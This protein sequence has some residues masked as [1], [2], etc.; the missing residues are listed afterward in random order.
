MINSIRYSPHIDG[1]YTDLRDYIVSVAVKTE[2]PYSRDSGAGLVVR[3]INTTND[4][5]LRGI[6]FLKEPGRCCSIFYFHRGKLTRQASY[7][8]PPLEDHN[9][10][11]F[12]TIRIKASGNRVTFII[13]GKVVAEKDDECLE[14]SACV[15]LM[16]IGPG[17]FCFDDLELWLYVISLAPSYFLQVC[18]DSSYTG[19]NVMRICDQLRNGQLVSVDELIYTVMQLG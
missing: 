8:L 6:L 4:E 12:E 16:A 13:N 17:T 14:G 7:Q 2:R 11:T 5:D 15:A 18:N 10:D 9:H 19:P 1:H 3:Y